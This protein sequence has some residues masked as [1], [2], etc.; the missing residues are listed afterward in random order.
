MVMP[1][2]PREERLG[3]RRIPDW[4]WTVVLAIL[5]IVAFGVAFVVGDSGPFGN[6]GF[7]GLILSIGLG[8]GLLARRAADLLGI[9]AG[10]VI[11]FEIMAVQEVA[12]RGSPLETLIY[13]FGTALIPGGFAAVLG[14]VVLGVRRLLGRIGVRS[15]L[16]RTA[17]GVGAFVGLGVLYV[18]VASTPTN[19]GTFRVTGERDIVV[20][21]VSG[22]SSWCRVTSVRETAADVT[23][24][25]ACVSLILGG[26]TAV[27]IFV[28]LPVRLGEPLGHRIVRNQHGG[29]VGPDARPAP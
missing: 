21:V 24:A 19:V 15:V 4:A 27:G 18:L 8:G 2:P 17:G 22:P 28:D 11:V 6:F 5:T 7:P 1:S 23:V 13:M 29:I 25:A 14:L 16:L 10:T 9:V 12:L 20:T 3:T 26:T